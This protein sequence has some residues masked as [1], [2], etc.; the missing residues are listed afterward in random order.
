M[1][2]QDFESYEI[3]S[4]SLFSWLDLSITKLITIDKFRS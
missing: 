3:D 2:G 4:Y 1:T